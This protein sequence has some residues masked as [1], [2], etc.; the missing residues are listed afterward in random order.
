VQSL[1]C[2][3][4]ILDVWECDVLVTQSLA[5]YNDMHRYI[6]SVIDVFSKYV[7][8]VPVKSKSGPSITSA[9]RSLFHDDHSRRPVWVRTNKG[10]AFLNF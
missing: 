1:Y 5:R 8:L 6:L 10:K 3:T 4:N 2:V 7:H 9:F